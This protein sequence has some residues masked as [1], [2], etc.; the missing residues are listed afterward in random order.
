MKHGVNEVKPEMLTFGLE[1][2]L[3]RFET[4]SFV[5]IHIAMMHISNHITLHTIVMEM[6]K[7]QVPYFTSSFRV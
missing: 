2:E 6:C 4:T 3:T 7:R 5:I 1:A